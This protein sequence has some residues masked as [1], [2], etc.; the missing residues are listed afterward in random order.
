MHARSRQAKRRTFTEQARRAQIVAAAI[1]T[2][3]EVGYRNASFSQIAKRAGLSS[4][5]LISYH[6]ASRDDL[7]AEVV[8]TVGAEM[9]RFMAERTRPEGG[10]TEPSAAQALRSDIEANIEF[11]DTHRE[12]MKAL[13]DIFINGGFTYD[14]GNENTAVSR[15]VD[16]L[17]A[18]QKSGEF[19]D[20][21]PTV[22]A[23]LIR[24]AV[25]GLPFLLDMR[26]G[27][28]VAAYGREVVTTFDLATRAQ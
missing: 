17:R 10:A 7:I 8:R 6:F 28:D 23:T 3:A 22:M 12:P 9:G 26:P 19:R 16:I 11:I 21:D 20:F 1:T 18:G 4:T 13:T 24:R 5:G 25:D 14:P 2:I 15:L 27:L